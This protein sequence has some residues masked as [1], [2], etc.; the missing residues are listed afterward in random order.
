[1]ILKIHWATLTTAGLLV[2]IAKPKA[3]FQMVQNALINVSD[4]TVTFAEQ[5][6]LLDVS[7]S[8]EKGDIVIILGPNG[9]GKSTL[10]KAL[11]NLLPYQGKIY[12]NKTKKVGY[13]TPQDTLLKKN[14]PPLTVQDFFAFKSARPEDQKLIFEELGLTTLLGKQFAT[15]S[16]GQ[17]QRMMLG[18]TLIDRP[19]LLLLDEPLTGIDVEGERAIH[20]LLSKISK[21]WD[22]TILLITHAIDAFTNEATKMLCLNK[23]IVYYG[24]PKK[25]S[26]DLLRTLYEK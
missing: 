25:L 12:R 8:V 18:W 2:I 11:L 14:L 1:M 4:L 13:L 3:R 24:P 9:A 10:L 6:V 21:K 23:E 19:S 7:F 22:L 5:K 26:A 15:L 17:F 16:T 20:F